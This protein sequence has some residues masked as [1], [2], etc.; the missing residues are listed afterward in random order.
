MASMSNL[1]LAL[2]L[3]NFFSLELLCSIYIDPIPLPKALWM[4]QIGYN[5]NTSTIYQ[6]GGLTTS[7]LYDHYNN[8]LK[9]YKRQMNAASSIWNP[10]ENIIP[11]GPISW[12]QSSVIIGDLVYLVGMRRID[13]PTNK[14]HAMLVF[15]M[16]SEWFI[17]YT[18]F[19]GYPHGGVEGCV[20]TNN[21]HIFMVGGCIDET[22]SSTYLPY[23]QIYDIQMNNWTVVNIP[24]AGWG[25]AC[26]LINDMIYIFGGTSNKIYKYD[27]FS[28]KSDNITAVMPFSGSIKGVHY[29]YNQHDYVYLGGWGRIIMFDVQ[30]ET[31]TDYAATLLIPV[32]SV[33]LLIY[34]DSL[35]VFGG[36]YYD[37]PATY[38]VATSALQIIGLPLFVSN[39]TNG[40]CTC[41]D[42]KCVLPLNVTG[43][44]VMI[45]MVLMIIALCV[46]AMVVWKCRRRMLKAP[47]RFKLTE[48]ANDAIGYHEDEQGEK[49]YFKE[50]IN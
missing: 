16:T 20:V 47:A 42:K 3:A 26:A 5:V 40:S 49:N 9:I 1:V 37:S 50:L 10:L 30:S 33:P 6:F 46:F 18:Q 2:C 15:N 21:T 19:T 48:D 43:V 28:Q 12:G 27:I 38:T 8:S 7:G 34:N 32:R 31:I 45:I 24:V 35:I 29:R 44:I 17:P 36:V 11:S 14:I 41:D 39:T 13:N 23:I 4:Q 22:N 25:S